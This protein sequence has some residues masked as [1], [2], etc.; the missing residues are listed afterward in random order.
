MPQVIL[1]LVTQVQRP[2]V[3]DV[4]WKKWHVIAVA[5][6]LFCPLKCLVVMNYL[7]TDSWHVA[8]VDRK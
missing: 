8:V 2:G 5:Q 4:L 3:R 1:V 6:H 7:Y